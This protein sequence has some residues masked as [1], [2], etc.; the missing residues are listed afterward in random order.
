MFEGYVDVAPIKETNSRL[1][2]TKRA[3]LCDQEN[4]NPHL[5]VDFSLQKYIFTEQYEI[6]FTSFLAKLYEWISRLTERKDFLKGKEPT[7]WTP[8]L[9]Q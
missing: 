1:D 3:V 9:I 4:G 2:R 6:L 7:V 8:K 5:T